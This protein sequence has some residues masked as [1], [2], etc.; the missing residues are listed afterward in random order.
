MFPQYKHDGWNKK[1]HGGDK[2]TIKIVLSYCFVL[3]KKKTMSW[4]YL[5]F[6]ILS[7]DSGFVEIYDYHGD[8]E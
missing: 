3:F 7:F 1:S 5:E 8:S 2:A 6:I 4:L